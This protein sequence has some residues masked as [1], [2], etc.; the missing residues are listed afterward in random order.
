MKPV[1]RIRSRTLVLPLRDIDT[2]QIFPARFLTTKSNRGLGK[3]LFADWRCD[4]Q[5]KPRQD[6]ILNRL[7]PGTHAIL[8][9]GHNFGCGSSREHAVWTLKDAGFQAVIST[10]FADIF[11]ANA[12]KNGL[13]PV[14]V[15]EKALAWLSAHPGTTA[16]IDVEELILEVAGEFCC[17]FQLD[18][19][20]R[21]CLLRGLDEL[22]YL[23][24]RASRISE[25]EAQR[26]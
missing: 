7:D 8:V 19:F 6:F 11:T 23:L 22:D 5:G 13:V 4:P 3:Y 12:R 14:V 15:D 18:P 10:E 9:A 26:R 2:D 21:Y 20:A 25:Y 1:R 17:H 16:V 24:Q